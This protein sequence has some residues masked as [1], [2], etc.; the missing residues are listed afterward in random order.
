MIEDTC[1]EFNALQRLDTCLSGKSI[2][3]KLSGLT[4]DRQEQTNEEGEFLNNL[5]FDS[6]FSVNVQ[7]NGYYFLIQKVRA[8]L[9]KLNVATF[10]SSLFV[11]E[12][13]SKLLPLRFFLFVC[14]IMCLSPSF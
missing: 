14:F 12:F 5:I 2:L 4:K 1:I 13:S 10:I 7:M 8:F 3:P 9:K 11:L 6:A